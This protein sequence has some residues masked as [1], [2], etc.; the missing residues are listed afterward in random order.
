MCRWF[1]KYNIRQALN[2]YRLIGLTPMRKIFDDPF[3]EKL[4]LKCTKVHF[5]ALST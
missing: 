1:M 3:D 2:V 5:G 4:Y